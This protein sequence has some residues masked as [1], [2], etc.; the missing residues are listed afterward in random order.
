MKSVQCPNWHLTKIKMQKQSPEG[1][2][3]KGCYEKQFKI[4]KKTPETEYL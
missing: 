3:L 2:L 4:Y 1:V